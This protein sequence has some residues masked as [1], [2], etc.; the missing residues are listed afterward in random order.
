MFC[1]IIIRGAT[2]QIDRLFTYRIP[3]ELR[4]SVVC[5]SLVSV[6][7]GN[8]NSQRVA[9]VVELKDSFDGDIGVVK[10]ICSVIS[11]RPVLNP[12]QIALIDKISDRF[13]C[14]KGDVIE[15][16]VPSCVINHKNPLEFFENR[17][18]AIA[19]NGMLFCI[20]HDN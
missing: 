3:D 5:G 2:K 10:D 20:V 17:E 9:V 14:T 12:D 4:E 18:P 8:S 7:F 13:N 16:M 11:D 1:S 19:G 15:L 6:P